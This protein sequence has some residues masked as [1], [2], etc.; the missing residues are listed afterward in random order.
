MLVHSPL[1]RRLLLVLA[2]VVGSPAAE[3]RQ[4]S[5]PLS[6]EPQR[7]GSFGWPQGPLLKPLLALPADAQPGPARGVLWPQDSEDPLWTPPEPDA[8]A[9]PWAAWVNAVE[10]SCADPEGKAALDMAQVAL[11]QGR[12][13]RAW[14][15]LARAAATHPAEA[16]ALLPRFWP[17]WA[18]EAG[19]ALDAPGGGLRALPA[20]ATLRPALPPPI[21]DDP[22]ILLAPRAMDFFGLQIGETLVDLR[23]HVRGDGV[24][25][26]VEHI[27]GPA[28]EF[29]VVLPYPPG[30]RAHLE[31]AD[32][33]RA[34]TVGA[35]L[36]VRL[37]PG[38]EPYRLWGRFRRDTERPEWRLPDPLPEQVLQA[39]L[40]LALDPQDPG[41]P[42]LVGLAPALEQM[43]GLEVRADDGSPRHGW[44]PIRIDLLPGPR[45]EAMLQTLLE[46]SESL[47]RNREG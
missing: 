31:Y 30:F 24:D 42:R 37:Q 45:R 34:D 3:S 46:L 47:R 11:E 5:L 32:W 8:L 14:R 18:P 33:E 36:P 22:E 15:T 27:S 35:P 6:V 39:G 2:A 13:E 16:A 4:D 29:Q 20:G 38:S 25:F 10:G 26:R 40:S 43:L 28:V 19:S 17:G 21:D 44:T 1:S 23:L 9:A 7:H 12:D 41:Y